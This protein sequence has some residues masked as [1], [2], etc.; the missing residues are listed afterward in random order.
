MGLD[1]DAVEETLSFLGIAGRIVSLEELLD[2]PFQP[3]PQLEAKYAGPTRYSDGSWPVFYSALE[4]DTAEKEVYYR[5]VKPVLGDPSKGRTAYRLSFKIRFRGEAKDLRPQVDE[6]PLLVHDSD[7]SFCQELGREAHST[8]IDGL[9][10]PSVRREGGTTV[11]V[12]SRGALSEPAAL[13]YAAF[14]IEPATGEIRI[15]YV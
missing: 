14:S 15:A 6:W 10:A 8:D 12:F 5:H 1:P 13:D 7:Y 11:P 3:K 9:F 4:P 2:A